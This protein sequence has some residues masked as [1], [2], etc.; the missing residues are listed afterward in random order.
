MT[1][2]SAPAQTESGWSLRRPSV[3]PCM[4]IGASAPANQQVAR[5]ALPVLGHALGP[6]RHIPASPYGSP[7]C[8]QLFDRYAIRT[9]MCFIHCKTV[10]S[11]S[12]LVSFITCRFHF[13]KAANFA[14]S[15]APLSLPFV[16]SLFLFFK[17]RAR[18]HD[19]ARGLGIVDAH[20]TNGHGAVS[21]TCPSA[22][23][24]AP[25]SNTRARRACS[26]RKTAPASPPFPC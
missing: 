9:F 3:P 21:G 2:A 14:L 6:C 8:M 13:I 16:S 15:F 4:H 26:C 19:C 22:P 25:R 23:R 7:Y 12:L 18:L 20:Y 24:A 11:V 1:D 5:R 17:R 10:S